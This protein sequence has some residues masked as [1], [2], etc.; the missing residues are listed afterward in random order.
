MILVN[1]IGF[2]SMWIDKRAAQA[3]RYRISEL[4]FILISLFG[5][6]MGVWLA[7]YFFRHKTQKVK[8]AIGIPLI[9]MLEICLFIYLF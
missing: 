9:M 3:K 2:I 7:M 4:F 1:G 5:G 6:S 8:F